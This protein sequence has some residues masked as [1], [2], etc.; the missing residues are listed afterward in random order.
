[1]NASN[2]EWLSPDVAI[3]DLTPRYDG[4]AIWAGAVH[5]R[6]CRVLD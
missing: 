1:M 6:S 2:Y 5:V 3:P 4:G